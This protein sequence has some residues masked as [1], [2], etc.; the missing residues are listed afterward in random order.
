MF[1]A[2]NENGDRIEATDASQGHQYYCQTCKAAVR[3]RKGSQRVAHFSHIT[4]CSDTWHYEEMSEWHKAWQERFPLKNREIVLNIDNEIHRADVLIDNTVIEFQH[5]PMTSEEFSERSR[6]YLNNGY[7]VIWLFDEIEHFRQGR[8]VD[9]KPGARTNIYWKYGRETF[10][11]YNI[12]FRDYTNNTITV[13]LQ[14]DDDES[15]SRSIMKVEHALCRM[16]LVKTWLSIPEYIDLCHNNSPPAGKHEE[17]TAAAPEESPEAGSASGSSTAW[18]T[19]QQLWDE[20][21]EPSQIVVENQYGFKYLIKEDPRT[22]KKTYGK[23]TG[24]PPYRSGRFLNWSFYTKFIDW[25]D[26]P[27]WKYSSLNGG[28]KND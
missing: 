6:F 4:A 27:Y 12:H 13:F 2:L 16:L 7:N 3:L 14:V 26:R 20:R 9:E 23:I 15:N 19:I 22:Q 11:L 25:W 5:S 24:Y 17:G 21:E 18:K 10:D 28:N 8:F 1:I